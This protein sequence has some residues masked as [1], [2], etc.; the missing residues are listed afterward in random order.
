M[1]ENEDMISGRIKKLNA[2]SGIGDTAV[3]NIK[4]EQTI[5]SITDEEN[6][7]CVLK[8]LANY[9]KD[10]DAQVTVYFQSYQNFFKKMDKF[11]GF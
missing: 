3:F 11:I 8:S 9:P 10:F 7:F 1:Y 4:P 5:M 6:S 2:V